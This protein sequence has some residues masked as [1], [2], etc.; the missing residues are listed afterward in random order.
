MR[1]IDTI[2][3]HCAVTRPNWW[4]GKS[5]KEKVDEV[6]RWH[7]EDNGWSDLGYHYMIDRDG[8]VAEGRPLARAGAHARGHNATS[9]GICLFGG[10]GSA[11]TDDFS[12]NFTAEQDDALRALIQELEAKYPIRKIIGHNEVSA[13]ACPGFQVREWLQGREPRPERTSPTESKTVQASVA[14]AAGGVGTA[15]SA[16]SGLDQY[17]QYIVLGFAGLVVLGALFIMRERL[18]AWSAGWK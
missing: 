3:V 6:R 4:E 7:V 16:L 14:T 17:A 18:K 15:V 1:N 10:H 9:V 13:K 5:T 8:T 11:R 12:D 2:V